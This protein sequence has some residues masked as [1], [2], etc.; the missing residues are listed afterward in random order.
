M[1]FEKF[2]TNDWLA[3]CNASNFTDGSSPLI[4]QGKLVLDSDVVDA[5]IVFDK[6][7]CQVTFELDSDEHSETYVYELTGADCVPALF[8]FQSE[9]MFVLSTL[10]NLGFERIC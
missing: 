2:Q 8:R 5:D 1:K 3:Y 6:R 7:G 4:A 10:T 9:D